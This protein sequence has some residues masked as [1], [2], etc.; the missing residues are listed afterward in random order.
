MS[1]DTFP[2]DSP[3]RIPFGCGGS[4]G[5]CIVWDDAED[6]VGCGCQRVQGVAPERAALDRRLA[7][8]GGAVGRECAVA[9][10]A[11]ATGDAAAHRPQAAEADRAHRVPPSIWSRSSSVSSRLRAAR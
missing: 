6:E 5:R 9:R 11:E 3:A 4:F 10:I 1:T 7:L 2:G 8:R